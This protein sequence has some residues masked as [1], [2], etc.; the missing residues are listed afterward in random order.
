MKLSTFLPWIFYGGTLLTTAYLIMTGHPFWISYL[1]SIVFFNVGI[2]GIWAAIGHL[3][4]PARAAHAIG[5]QPCG[6]QTEIGAT[7]L[8]IGVTGIL[9]MFFFSWVVPIALVAAILY[10]GCIYIHIYDRIVNKNNAPCNSGPMLYNT[11]I[12]VI[13]IIAAFIDMWI[14]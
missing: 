3:F 14:G 8:A 12:V 1:R 4:F 5:W 9:S 13:S 6:F 7:N 10:A 11:I 2:Q